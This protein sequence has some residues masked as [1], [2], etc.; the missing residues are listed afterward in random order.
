MFKLSYEHMEL[1][2]G[3][4]T[5]YLLYQPPSERLQTTQTT[6]IIKQREG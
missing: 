2:L 6:S 4:V 1:K 5:I 3:I